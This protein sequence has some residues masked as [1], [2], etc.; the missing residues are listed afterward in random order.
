MAAQAAEARTP[1][2]PYVSQQIGCSDLAPLLLARAVAFGDC[3]AWPAMPEHVRSWLDQAAERARRWSE[4]PVPQELRGQVAVWCSERARLVRVEGGH[5]AREHALSLAATML[6]GEDGLEGAVAVLMAA[7]DKV[8]RERVK[9]G[10]VRMLP[11]LVAVKAGL[12]T[13]PAQASYAR[14]GEVLEAA[15]WR[16]WLDEADDVAE[17]HYSAAGIPR[18]LRERFT[19][20]KVAHGSSPLITYPDGWGTTWYGRRFVVNCKTTFDGKKTTVDPPAWLQVQGEMV[21]MDAPLAV[22]PHGLGWAAD[23]MTGP[24]ELRPIRVDWI[25]ADTSAQAA[26]V[27]VARE[28]MGWILEESQRKAGKE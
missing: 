15:L 28:S 22:L 25:E 4:K 13:R 2:V 10:K 16:R 23:Y 14:A 3:S 24:P 27:Q 12:R 17:A 1:A 5:S 19:A 18:E 26:L 8:T 6:E 9:S 20:P 11:E 21:C 7:L